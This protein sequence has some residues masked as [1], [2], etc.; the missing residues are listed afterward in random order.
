MRRQRADVGRQHPLLDRRGAAPDASTGCA[1]PGRAAA[2]SA[3]GRRPFRRRPRSARRALSALAIAIAISFSTAGC[4]GSYRCATASSERSTA[5]V[6]WIRSLVPIDRKSSFVE[7]RRDREHRRRESRSCRRPRRPD[8]TARPAR[9]ASPSPARSSPASG[10]SR[11][12]ER[13]HRHQDLHACRSATR[14]G[15]RGAASGRAAA[16]RGRSG[17]RAGRAPDSAR[18]ATR[19]SRPSLCLSAPRSNVRIVTGLPSMPC[20]DAAVGLELLVLGRQPLAVQEQEL[21]AEEPDARR[22]RSR[23]PARGRPA[24]RCWPGARSSCPSSV[25]AGLVLQARSFARSSSS[26][27]CFSRYSAS[28]D[29]SGLTMTTSLRAVDDQELVLADQRAARCAWPTTA[30]T[31]RLRATIA[32]C[33]VTP[34]RSVM[35][36]A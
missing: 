3:A 7:E 34:P 4:S 5:S 22:R 35:K 10:R 18:R 14:A 15:S 6:Y 16:R 21:G 24:A 1:G 26:S 28:T 20:G 27:L 31:A 25:V 12:R 33:D 11:R 30:G 29:L 23:A 2:A 36:P 17:P 8:R 13:Q 9:A 19:P 32:V